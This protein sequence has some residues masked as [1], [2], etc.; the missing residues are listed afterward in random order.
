MFLHCK[1]QCLGLRVI[2]MQVQRLLRCSKVLT[3]L[4]ATACLHKTGLP[5]QKPNQCLLGSP[6]K[7]LQLRSYPTKRKPYFA[8]AAMYGFRVASCS[9]WLYSCH[10]WCITFTAGV[11]LVDRAMPARRVRSRV[12]QCMHSVFVCFCRHLRE[13]VL[14][15]PQV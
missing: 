13:A 5:Q 15:I 14:R 4:L 11:I 12:N 3:V 10:S 1:N 7:H 2:S 6:G 9:P 8:F